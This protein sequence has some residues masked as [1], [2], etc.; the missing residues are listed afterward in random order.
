MILNTTRLHLILNDLLYFF[1]HARLL[2]LPRIECGQL[3]VLD[4]VE[5]IDVARCTYDIGH[6]HRATLLHLGDLATHTCEV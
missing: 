5:L 4:E 2:G 1:I 3:A 6:L